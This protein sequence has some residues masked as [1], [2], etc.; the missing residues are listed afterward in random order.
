MVREFVSGTARS[1]TVK[2]QKFSSLGYAVSGEGDT[3]SSRRSVADLGIGA[4][5]AADA[6]GEIQGGQPLTSDFSVI[7]EKR[8]TISSG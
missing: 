1:R 2:E 8:F 5:L 6:C 4:G 3:T 7:K